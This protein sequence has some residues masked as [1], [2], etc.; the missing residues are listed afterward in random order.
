MILELVIG[1]AVAVGAALYVWHK[2]PTWFAT[3]AQVVVD[4]VNKIDDSVKATVTHIANTVT[5]S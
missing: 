2:W 4:A 1:G 5:K 3:E